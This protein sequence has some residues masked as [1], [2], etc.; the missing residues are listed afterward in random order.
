MLIAFVVLPLLGLIMLFHEHDVSG[1]AF[2]KDY[3]VQVVDRDT[4]RIS[5]ETRQI[6][7]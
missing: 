4:G 1:S 3:Q 2:S 5:V 6:P 7:I